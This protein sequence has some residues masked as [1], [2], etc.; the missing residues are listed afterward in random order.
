MLWSLVESEHIVKLHHVNHEE[1]SL[2]FDL[3]LGSPNGSLS[4]LLDN[5]K[6]R[7]IFSM[8]WRTS[9]ADPWV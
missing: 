2:A 6:K 3:S 9:Y 7:I 8:T 5:Y 4:A 1:G